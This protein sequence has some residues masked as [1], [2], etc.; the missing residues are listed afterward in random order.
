MRKL[1]AW[2]GLTVGGW[3]GWAVGARLSL[4]AAF[5]LSIVG[6]GLGLYVGRR[7]ADAFF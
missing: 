2:I 1:L 6:T 5:V 4:S 3:V 7:I